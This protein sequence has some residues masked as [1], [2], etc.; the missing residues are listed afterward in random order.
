MWESGL[1]PAHIVETCQ[2]LVSKG[3]V[4]RPEILLELSEVAGSDERHDDA[5]LLHSHS[6]KRLIGQHG[7][8]TDAEREEVLTDVLRW[9]EGRVDG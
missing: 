2:V 8:L 5:V 1:D 3:D 7:G 4:E 6:D 9:I